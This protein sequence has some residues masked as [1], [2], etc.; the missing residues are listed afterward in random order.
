MNNII[1][2]GSGGH[3]LS[4]IS[5][6]ESLALYKISGIIDNKLE[7]VSKLKYSLIGND[8]DLEKLRK[9]FNNAF[10][11]IGHV[12]NYES[13]LKMYN[14]LKELNYNLPNIIAQSAI[15][16][17]ESSI[18][19]STIV[20]NGVI[21]GPQAEVGYNS[22]INTSSTIEHGSKIGNN[23]HISTGVV[24]N[25]DVKIGNNTFIGSGS[26]IREGISIGSQCF[27]KMGSLI[28]KDIE[29]NEQI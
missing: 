13:R 20:M 21:I 17:E 26:I 7:A 6:I 5:I 29:D 23:T 25:G 2:I 9:K 10:V 1:I 18:K 15:I 11:G 14:Q 16:A 22:I 19:E 12:K 3:S 24:I 28:T 4:S 27:I 8:L